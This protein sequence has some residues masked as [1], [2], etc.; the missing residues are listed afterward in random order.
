[1]TK[2]II[3]RS[4]YVANS[5]PNSLS[6]VFKHLAARW[7]KMVPAYGYVCNKMTSGQVYFSP[8]DKIGPIL[9]F[10]HH[11]IANFLQL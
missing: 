7:K 1:M 5:Y 4:L 3:L 11:F 9:T 10:W 6:V 2:L 8:M